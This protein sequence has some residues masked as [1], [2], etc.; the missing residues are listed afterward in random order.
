MNKFEID[1]GA[2]KSWAQEGERAGSLAAKAATFG[3]MLVMEILLV[4]P[5]MSPV[6]HQRSIG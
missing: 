1:V 4:P 5:P 2:L 6:L 3:E